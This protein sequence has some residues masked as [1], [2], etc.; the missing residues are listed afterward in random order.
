MSRVVQK[1]SR[2]DP[3]VIKRLGAAGVAT[4]HEAQGRSGLMG[5]KMRPIQQDFAI[6]G[7]AVTISA[8]PGDN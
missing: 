1:I 7:S 4:V 5:S 6:A 3:D 8:A 2:A